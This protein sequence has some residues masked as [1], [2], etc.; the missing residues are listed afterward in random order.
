MPSGKAEV[1]SSTSSSGSIWIVRANGFLGEAE[2]LARDP[3][4]YA[5][6][7]NLLSWQAAELGLKSLAGGHSIPYTHDLKAVMEH[8][9]GN[10]VLDAQTYAQLQVSV[11]TVTSSGSYNNLRYPDQNPSFWETRPAS[12]TRQRVEA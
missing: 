7:V 6:A 9:K 5:P 8:L 2:K 3:N 11:V 1:F 4:P 10:G 12:E